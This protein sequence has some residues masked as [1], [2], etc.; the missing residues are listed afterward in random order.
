[1][2]TILTE[3]GYTVKGKNTECTNFQCAVDADGNYGECCMRRMLF[4]EPDFAGTQSLLEEECSSKGISAIFLPKFH[5]ELNPIEQCWGYSK[6]LSLGA[7]AVG[8]GSGQSTDT[9]HGRAHTIDN[10]SLFYC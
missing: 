5:C 1:M 3:R 7:S 8:V 4:N 9:C 2:Q 10:L 6:R